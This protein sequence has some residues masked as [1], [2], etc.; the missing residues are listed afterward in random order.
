MSTLA[1]VVNDETNI[2]TDDAIKIVR[3]AEKVFGYILTTEHDGNYIRLMKGD[4]I[5]CLSKYNAS[6]RI[7]IRVVILPNGRTTHAYIN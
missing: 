4:A 6:D 1:Q 5:A 7:K 3:K 2:P